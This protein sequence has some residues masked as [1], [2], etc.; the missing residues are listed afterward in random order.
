MHQGEYQAQKILFFCY[1]SFYL[2]YFR[3]AAGVI[4]GVIVSGVKTN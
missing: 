4:F 3:V 2:Y 1:L